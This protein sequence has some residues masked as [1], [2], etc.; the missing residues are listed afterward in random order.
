MEEY[1]KIKEFEMYEISNL[2]NLRRIYSYGYKY[3]KR[4]INKNEYPK[5]T[6]SKNGNLKSFKIHILVAKCFLNYVP[7]KG[8]IVVD[9]IDNN[10][11]NYNLNN[12]QIITM[13]ENL[14]KDSKRESKYPNVYKNRK[15]WRARINYNNYNYCLGT[16]ETQELANEKIIEFL[17]KMEGGQNG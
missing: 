3:I 16:F 14:V 12:L 9:H 15:K 17:D 7:N 13:R 11:L 8:V 5:Y 1:R 6:L 4:C 10:K 2:G